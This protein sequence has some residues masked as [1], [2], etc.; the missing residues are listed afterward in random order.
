MAKLDIGRVSPEAL[1]MM[2]DIQFTKS[3]MKKLHQNYFFTSVDVSDHSHARFHQRNSRRVCDGKRH[4][5]SSA[6]PKLL[7]LSYQKMNVF[8]TLVML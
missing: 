5:V 7:C 8:S 6:S 2:L 1:C 3:V 4:P